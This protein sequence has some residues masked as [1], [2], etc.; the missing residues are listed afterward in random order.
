MS[1]TTAG[2]DHPRYEQ[3]FGQFRAQHW[4]RQK[5]VLAL[6]GP[7]VSGLILETI[8]SQK[9]CLK[10]VDSPNP[11]QNFRYVLFGLPVERVS[12]AISILR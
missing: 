2:T 11:R 5:F 12:R 9:F 3:M 7:S 6:L 10:R 8:S 1:K 4:G